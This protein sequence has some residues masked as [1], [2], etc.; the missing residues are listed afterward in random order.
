MGIK[1]EQFDKY[2]S[3]LSADDIKPIYS[4]LLIHEP[5]FIDNLDLLMG[6]K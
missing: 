2:I 5:D 6:D 1:T 4:I 3:N